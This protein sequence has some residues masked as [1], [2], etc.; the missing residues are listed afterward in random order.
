MALQE[1]GRVRLSLFLGSQSP[2]VTFGNWKSNLE[3]ISS[4]T[5]LC[6]GLFHLWNLETTSDKKFARRAATLESRNV[7]SLVKFL[8]LSQMPFAQGRGFLTDPLLSAA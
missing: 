8:T 5:T 6:G 1:A 2:E 4:S 7:Q 3:T